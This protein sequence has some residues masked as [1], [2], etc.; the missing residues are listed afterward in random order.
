M[1]ENFAREVTFV[2]SLLAAHKSFLPP[3]DC[4]QLNWNFVVATLLNNRCAG[5]AYDR[6]RK[7]GAETPVP[8]EVMTA[9]G[10]HYRANQF[11]N[12]LLIEEAER[13]MKELGA[14]NVPVIPVKG[15]TL[16]NSVYLDPGHRKLGDLD[17]LVAPANA[18]PAAA[19]LERL[20]YRAQQAHDPARGV[21]DFILSRG[22]LVF[23]LD[24]SWTLLHRTTVT[25]K[26]LSVVDE[27]AA[28]ASR[29][30]IANVDVPVLKRE[31]EI[32]H[33]AGHMAL[34]HNLSFAPGLVDLCL[35][36]GRKGQPA[37]DWDDIERQAER[38]GLLR[39]LAAALGTAQDLCGLI[40]GGT[41]AHRWDKLQRSIE[42]TP[43]GVFLDRFWIIGAAAFAPAAARGN[44]ARH[45]WARFWWQHGLRETLRQRVA[46]LKEYIVPNGE[47][48]RK[49]YGVTDPRLAL[50]VRTFHVPV[51]AVLTAIAVGLAAIC[52]PIYAIGS[53]K[54]A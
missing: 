7:S 38:Y 24:L 9:L 17:F 30:T 21:R 23:R 47:R 53:R 10:R 48:I 36:V 51:F 41:I 18:C 11:A 34:H 44:G 31:D 52:A 32:L 28:R 14:G 12:T 22:S 4:E 20:G 49:T 13:V 29:S 6:L 1:S 54:R 16:L 50:A 33:I 37:P 35:L 5:L 42:R 19:V 46:Y 39:P 27:L 15:L 45:N 25:A 3:A 2:G 40:I 43:A 26:R 8:G